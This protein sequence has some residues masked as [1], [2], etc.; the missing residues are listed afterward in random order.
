M[1]SKKTILNKTLW[2][3]KI[4][5]VRGPIET[6]FNKIRLDK[7]EKPDNHLS[8][9]FKKIRKN[10]R[11]EHLT[12]Y[13][14]TEILYKTISKKFKIKKQS[15]VLTPGSD[16]AIKSCLDLFTVK[17][18]KI[19]TIDPTFAMVEVY[20]KIKRVKQIKINYNRK[21]ELDYKKLFKII[22]NEKISLVILANPN[23][24]TGTI[25]PKKILSEILQSCKKYNVPVLI[26]E[27]YFGFYKY[28]TIPLIKKY[29][30]LV[31]CRTFSKVYGLAGCRVGFLATNKNLAN[32]L[33]NLRP[34]YEINSIGAMIVNEILKKDS[35][36]IKNLK[37]QLDGKKYLLK[38]LKELKLQFLDGHAN[39]IYINLGDKKNRAERTFLKNNI[40]IR[41]GL[42]ISGY[43]NFLRI[44]LGPKNIM[45]NVVKILKKI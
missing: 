43:E 1:K 13:P 31:V 29:N 9:L 4:H 24:P 40:L 17:D 14:E 2:A 11:H 42:N 8:E 37:D 36:V 32:R 3:N 30:N 7:N 38:E 35:F 19:I 15:L 18:D 22:K 5:R 16:A 26:D 20:S 41:G 45:Q 34:M 39:F 27:A 21:L 28:S 10:I 33:Y 12:A 6:R 44:S 25:I 23:S